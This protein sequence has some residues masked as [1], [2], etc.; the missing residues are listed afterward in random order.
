M[1]EPTAAVPPRKRWALIAAAAIAVV[2]LTLAVAFALGRGFDQPEAQDRQAVGASASAAATTPVATPTASASPSPSSSPSSSPS[3]KPKLPTK[4]TDEGGYCTDRRCGHY[5]AGSSCKG[6][7]WCTK[8]ALVEPGTWATDGG[9][10]FT[11]C[12]WGLSL[13][14]EYG[15]EDGGY[16]TSYLEVVVPKGAIFDTDDCDAGWKWLHP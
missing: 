5:V 15:L 14:P 13:P 16:A 10:G 3:Y 8:K 12:M 4:M 1:T 6:I 7:E 9:S 2:A 11:D